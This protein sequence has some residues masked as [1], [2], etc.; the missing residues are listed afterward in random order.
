M[1]KYFLEGLAL[2][3]TAYYICGKKINISLI[4]GLVAFVAYIILDNFVFTIAGTG[5]ME[6]IGGGLKRRRKNRRKR[7]ICRNK[8]EYIY[9]CESPPDA[10]S[11]FRP[12]KDDPLPPSVNIQIK[13]CKGYCKDVCNNKDVDIFDNELK[14]LG[15]PLKSFDNGKI[16]AKPL[17]DP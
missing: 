8:C 6:F 10:I 1:I 17:T 3:T 14:I 4:L 16:P 7:H 15:V 11:R 13:N 9:N 12:Y 5:D 2:F